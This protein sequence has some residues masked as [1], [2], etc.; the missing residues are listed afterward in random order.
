MLKQNFFLYY[1]FFGRFF[2][3]FLLFLE[4]LNTFSYAFSFQICAHNI[5]NSIFLQNFYV[6]P[7]NSLQKAEF[8]FLHINL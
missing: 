1:G 8:D 7:K 5:K 4:N 2:I 3:Y 6:H